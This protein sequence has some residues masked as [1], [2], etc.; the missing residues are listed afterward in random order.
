MLSNTARHLT[1]VLGAVNIAVAL[2]G[3]NGSEGQKLRVGLLDADVYGPSIP[4]LMHLHGRPE[5]GKGTATYV[6]SHSTRSIVWLYAVLLYILCLPD[7][8]VDRRMP[9]CRPQDDTTREL[10]SQVHVYGVPHGGQFA[11]QPVRH[12]LR[13][14][15]H[16]CVT[17]HVHDMCHG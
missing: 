9:Q 3:L 17:R 7:N 13:H 11:L 16:L 2:A 6:A 5:T 4:Q 12:M 10:G 8:H 1:S 14:V 15:M